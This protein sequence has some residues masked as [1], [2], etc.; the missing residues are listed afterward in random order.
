MVQQTHP[1]SSQAGMIIH[2]GTNDAE[3]GHMQDVPVQGFTWTWYYGPFGLDDPRSS[4]HLLLSAE[5]ADAK[6][7]KRELVALIGRTGNPIVTVHAN[8]LPTQGEGE[9]RMAVDLVKWK[10]VL[11]LRR[12]QDQSLW[13]VWADIKIPLEHTERGND[14][15]MFV[16]VFDGHGGSPAVA[17]LA[18]RTFNACL[19]WALAGVPQVDG[20]TKAEDM[21]RTISLA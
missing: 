18:R 19:A 13:D 16:S 20:K 11:R 9:D 10:D 6:L 2:T 7:I 21:I 15:L 1:I 14:D 5:K 8:Y 3:A 12:T 4:T 17:E